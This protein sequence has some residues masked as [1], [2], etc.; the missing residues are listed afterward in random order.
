MQDVQSPCGA[1]TR[2]SISVAP[3]G[4]ASP[5]AQTYDLSRDQRRGE[6]CGQSLTRVSEK[7][8]YKR[9]R[10]CDDND[11]Q[12]PTGREEIQLP[13][14]AV[15]NLGDD[16]TGGV[17]HEHRVSADVRQATRHNGLVAEPHFNRR[18]LAV[19]GLYLFSDSLPLVN[20]SACP[21]LPP[22]SDGR[23]RDTRTRACAAGG[24]R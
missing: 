17:G 22:T 24:S 18:L 15:G 6:M 19:F 5:A 2:E 8:N 21:A 11:R 13:D 16:A 12:R 7:E 3:I 10:H 9:R 1:F 4:V 20:A 23:T 14:L